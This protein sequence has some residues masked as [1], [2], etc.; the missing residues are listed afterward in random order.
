MELRILPGNIAN[1][2]AA[3]EVVQRPASVVK[4]L[5]ENAVDAGAEQIS[6]IIKDSGRTLIQVIDNGKGMNPDDA[7]LCFERHATSKIATAEDL[8]DITTFGFRGEALASIAAVAEVTLKTRTEDEE[9]GCQV[10]FAASVHNST[11][12]IATPK[13]TNIAV[14]NLFYNVPARRKFLKSDNVEFKHIV[15]EFTK[16]ALTRPEIGFSLSH[17]GKDVFVLKPAKSLKYRIM[18]LLGAS[19]TGDVVDVCADTSVV[20]LRGFVGR[21]D[22]ARKTLGNQFFFVNGRYFRSP[23]LHKAVMKAYEG[24]IADGVTPSYFI[25][26]E[27]DPHSVD[28]NISPTKSEVKFEDDSFIF[29]VVYAS[30]KEVLGKNAFAGGIDFSNPEA[31]DMPVLGS[32]FSEYQPESIP[33]VAVDGGYNPFDPVT[34]A[35]SATDEYGAVGRGASTGSATELG[36]PANEFGG[37]AGKGYGSATGWKDSGKERFGQYVDRREDYGKL[38]EEKTLPVT[39]TIILGGKYIVAPARDGLMIVNVRRARE[40]ILYDRALAALTKNEHVTQANMFPVKV[41]VGAANRAVFDDKAELLARLGFDISPFG[42]DTIVVNG[43]PEGYS[44]EAGK[45]QT[46]VS[47]LLLILSDD[48]SSLPGVMEAAMAEKIALLGASSCDPLASPM[49]ARHLLDTLLSSSNPELTGN[50]KRIMAIMT[51]AQVEK[52]F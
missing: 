39:Q 29:Q 52:L 31:N 23:Y 11:T 1:M 8:E 40:R 35:G 38:F 25:Y 13:G 42:T 18:D 41:E 14:R 44:C 10:E 15:E 24:M 37:P 28:V 27:V 2:I 20:S 7:V 5:V 45:I 49:E 21:P 6:V 26:L 32:H 9:V 34:S 36:G 48:S 33:Q 16:V 19:V 12:E 30:V 43:V 4:E 46:M 17:N 50:G 3:G 51:S 47:D 22:T